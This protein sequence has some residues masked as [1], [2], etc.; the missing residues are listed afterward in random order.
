MWLVFK[1]DRFIIDVEMAAIEKDAMLLIAAVAQ[2]KKI[3]RAKAE[4]DAEMN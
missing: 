4:R 1:W 2:L 3:A